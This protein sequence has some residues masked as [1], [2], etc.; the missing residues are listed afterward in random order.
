LSPLEFVWEGW[1]KVRRF[2]LAAFRKKYV[3][4]MR[5]FRRGEC[6]RCGM[7]CTFMIR[8]PFLEGEN[9]CT[10]YEKRPRQCRLFP[11]EPRD[12]RGRFSAC[13]HYFVS[14]AEVARDNVGRETTSPGATET[15]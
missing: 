7:C 3:E 4:Q 1:A 8:C 12:L 15:G 6:R 9:Q 14:E 2:Y 10:I 11:I 13:G 5:E